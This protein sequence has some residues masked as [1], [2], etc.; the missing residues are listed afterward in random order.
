MKKIKVFLIW[1]Y[2]NSNYYKKL[3]IIGCAWTL[4]KNVKAVGCAMKLYNMSSW[5][6][7]LQHGL[8]EKRAGII[9]FTIIYCAYHLL[10]GR[11]NHVIHTSIIHS[12]YIY[13]LGLGNLFLFGGICLELEII[14]FQYIN[15]DQLHKQKILLPENKYFGLISNICSTIHILFY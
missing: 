2:E 6:E 8:L 7:T 13:N 15:L 1:A 10:F 9:I 11:E 14:V 5:W 3:A 12:L 4:P